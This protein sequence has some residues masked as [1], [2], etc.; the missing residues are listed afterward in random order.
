MRQ[1]LSKNET[2]GQWLDRNHTKFEF[3]EKQ[4]LNVRFHSVKKGKKDD[5]NNYYVQWK[6]GRI[7]AHENLHVRDMTIGRQTVRG[8]RL[9][10]EKLL[11]I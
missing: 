5:L 1:R 2:T 10:F 4:V 7:V 9:E 3:M 6:S 8:L 11:G